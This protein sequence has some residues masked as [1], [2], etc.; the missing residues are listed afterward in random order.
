MIKSVEYDLSAADA[1]W[2]ISIQAKFIGTDF[3]TPT[4]KSD[5]LTSIES[6]LPE[7]VGYYTQ[8]VKL[9]QDQINLDP[10]RAGEASNFSNVAGTGVAVQPVVPAAYTSTIAS[11]TAQKVTSTGTPAPAVVAPSADEMKAFVNGDTAP[12]GI[13]SGAASTFNNY[14]KYKTAS[15][16]MYAKINYDGNGVVTSVGTGDTTSPTGDDLVIVDY[17]Q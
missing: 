5:V 8:A 14:I 4:I 12:L 10:E 16:T 3:D 7:C 17:P 9:N 13:K 1:V 15:I 6:D 2:T 11:P